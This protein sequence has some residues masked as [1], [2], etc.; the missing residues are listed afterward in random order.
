ML[1]FG[2]KVT[3]RP[4][5]ISL[6]LALIVGLLFGLN[7]SKKLGLQMGIIIFIMLFI[8]H[9]FFILPT[10]FNYWDS[11]QNFIRYSDIKNWKN[12]LIAMFFPKHLALRDIPKNQIKIVLILG[13][14]QPKSNLSS[15]LVVSEESGF[16]YNLLLMLNEPVKVRLILVNNKTVDLDLSRDYVHNAQ[17]TIGKLRLFLKGFNPSVVQLSEETKKFISI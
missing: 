17:K 11:E 12:R 8:G 3:S 10:I 15:K 9:Y 6:S 16:M 2:K 4:M 5:L 7:I 13:L 14:P 1:K